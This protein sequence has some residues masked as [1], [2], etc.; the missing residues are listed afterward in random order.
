MEKKMEY[1]YVKPT[2]MKPVD[3]YGKLFVSLA[4][5]VGVMI[6]LMMLV[7]KFGVGASIGNIVIGLA[8]TLLVVFGALYM[9]M[10]T[11]RRNIE[12]EKEHQWQAKVMAEM[13][14]A[15][16]KETQQGQ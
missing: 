16:A 5:F 12:L 1:V 4:M 7:A 2:P 14:A 8:V 10:E 13:N 3:F 11:D 6:G 9:Y 15:K